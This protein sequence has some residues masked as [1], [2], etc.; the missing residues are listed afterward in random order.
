MFVFPVRL[1]LSLHKTTLS[2]LLFCA[3]VRFTNKPT[4]FSYLLNARKHYCS[5]AKIQNTATI[6]IPYVF[7]AFFLYRKILHLL[8]CN[9]STVRCCSRHLFR[10]VHASFNALFSVS[11]NKSCIVHTFQPRRDAF[12]FFA[13]INKTQKKSER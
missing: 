3:C 11:L 4:L 7:V 8:A 9:L 6:N 10:V 2:M 5:I 1:M 13:K 12:G